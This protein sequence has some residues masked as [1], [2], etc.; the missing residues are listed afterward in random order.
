MNSND[1]TL[2][3]KG[4]CTFF[5][6]GSSSTFVVA[7][8]PGHGIHRPVLTAYSDFIDP[9]ATTWQPDEIG[10]AQVPDPANPAQTVTVQIATWSLL[11]RRVRFET[12]SGASWRKKEDLLTFSQYHKNFHKMSEQEIWESFPTPGILILSEGLGDTADPRLME[13]M[14]QSGSE[15]RQVATRLEWSSLPRKLVNEGGHALK[16]VQSAFATVSNVSPIPSGPDL[17][18]VHHH[19]DFVTLE[20]GDMPIHLRI[21]GGFRMMTEETWDCVPPGEWP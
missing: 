14:T 11:G 7:L 18:H 10:H 9:S 2:H 4:L 5:E 1:L 12:A 3:F 20:P 19:Y 8:P 16:F 15:S 21:P 13:V 17:V 6:G